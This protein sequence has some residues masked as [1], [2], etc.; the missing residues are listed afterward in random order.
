MHWVGT[1]CFMDW[2]NWQSLPLNQRSHLPGCSAIYVVADTDDFV[3]YVGQATNLKN[4]WIGKRHHR[5]P[6]LLRSNR[7]LNH[8]IY[9]QFCPLD[10]LNAQELDCIKRF[11]PELNGREVKT[12]LPRQ[13][14]QQ[15]VDC[16]IKRILGVL[17]RQTLLFPVIRSIIAGQYN[18]ETGTRCTIV[19]IHIN[20]FEVLAN[21]A[22]KR[23]HKIN[24]AWNTH[25]SCC[26][27]DQDMYH[28]RL[29][30]TYSIDGQKVEFIDASDFLCFLENDLDFSVPYL[31]SE[32]WFG[33]TVKFLN[34]LEILDIASLQEEYA[35]LSG[36]KKTLTDVA[37]LLYRR[38][39]LRLFNTTQ[40]RESLLC[41]HGFEDSFFC[42]EDL[43]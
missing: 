18:D 22:Q 2:K 1:L 39:M 34:D 29:I 12:Y 9:W 32:Q 42:L 36:G 17:N 21:S 33:V 4:R 35:F 3:W 28:E 20:D 40:C 41:T 23:D 38:P 25:S 19:M 31:N 24:A 5:Y 6:Q 15:Q 43:L 11:V 26:G 37:Y 14:K 7:K 30:S 13:S 10:Q 8:R 27:R 16:E